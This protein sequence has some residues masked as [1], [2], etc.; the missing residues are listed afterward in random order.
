MADLEISR[1]ADNT[2]HHLKQ[3]TEI[4]RDGDIQEYLNLK[5]KGEIFTSQQSSMVR[6]VPHL[7]KETT[8][9]SSSLTFKIGHIM[10]LSH[11]QNWSHHDRKVLENHLELSDVRQPWHKSPRESN[12]VLTSL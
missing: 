5:T 12:P 1:G 8:K 6:V 9:M 11:L 4:S 2:D 3:L 10:I 7:G